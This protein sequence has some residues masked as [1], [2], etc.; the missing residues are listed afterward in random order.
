MT[1]K[2]FKN[3]SKEKI[4]VFFVKCVFYFFKTIGFAPVSLSETSG[5]RNKQWNWKFSYSKVGTA[6]NVLFI[7]VYI[8]LQFFGTSSAFNNSYGGY[9]GPEKILFAI[10][11]STFA[12]GVVIILSMFCVRQNEIIILINKIAKIKKLLT[13]NGKTNEIEFNRTILAGIGNVIIFIGIS[14]LTLGLKIESAIVF[15]AYNWNT[16]LN[17]SLFLH[18]SLVLE[19]LKKLF[20]LVHDS[21]KKIPRY[22][23][24]HLE[25]NSLG[26]AKLTASYDSLIDVSQ[27]ISKLYSLPMLLGLLN[28]FNYS[29]LYSYGV[30][31]YTS[32]EN[33]IAIKTFICDLC[34]VYLNVIP[35]LISVMNVTDTI[36]KVQNFLNSFFKI[37]QIEIF[38]IP[39]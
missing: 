20:V 35:I 18:Y 29:I 34:H 10:C 21:Y 15:N 36:R 24:L 7:L 2:V 1:L 12:C 27:S 33:N 3:I 38:Y 8:I 14:V 16:F 26:F 13:K 31:K 32:S 9:Y 4:K 25:D 6:Y 37:C 5:T 17:C 39:E 22:Y 11:D 30:I 19:E 23:N 28:S